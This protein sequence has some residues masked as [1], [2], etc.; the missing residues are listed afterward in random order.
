MD[1]LRIQTALQERYERD[2]EDRRVLRVLRKVRRRRGKL[3]RAVQ[4]NSPNI[5]QKAAAHAESMLRALNEALDG[6]RIV[7]LDA[8][9][10]RDGSR[11]ITEIG[12][13][14]YENGQL[15]VRNIR[16]I[17]DYLPRKDYFLGETEV[18]S[19]AE[20][21]AV[22]EEIMESADLLT[23]HALINDRGQFRKWRGVKVRHDRVFDTQVY[24]KAL[25]G[26]S[27]MSLRDLM[28]KL[29]ITPKGLHSAGNDTM[30]IIMVLLAFA[31][32][33]E[34]CRALG[35][36]PLDPA[37]DAKIEAHRQ[38]QKA[39]VK[40]RRDAERG[41]EYLARMQMPSLRRDLIEAGRVYAGRRPDEWTRRVLRIEE[42]DQPRAPTGKVKVVVFTKTGI[43]NTGK[44]LREQ[45]VSLTNF[46]NWAVEAFE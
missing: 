15:T 6:K 12:L 45:T 44:G 42:V 33:I 13:A 19:P 11:A 38:A 31:G 14:V 3:Q 20:A 10:S 7:A 29:D 37:K 39:K 17:P 36:S 8:E 35:G 4:R 28:R 16:V 25:Y 41:P 9:W 32:R 26:G 22:T 5:K 2:P 30:S 34:E 18:L 1:L 46:A 27:A 40:E 21:A 43:D 23:G 24:A